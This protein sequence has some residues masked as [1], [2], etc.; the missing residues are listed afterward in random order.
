VLKG[1]SHI[2]RPTQSS[3]DSRGALGRT[4][5]NAAMLGEDDVVDAVRAYL[6]ERGWQYV[7]SAKAVGKQ[8]GEDLVMKRGSTCLS[9]EAKGETSSDPDSTRY[10]EPFDSG[11]IASHIGRAVV[12]ALGVVS[13]GERR[14]AIALPATTAHKSRVQRIAPALE[15]LA[16]TVLWVAADRTVTAAPD[17]LPAE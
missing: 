5:H 12:T 4:A 6:T 1:F 16:V 11:Q 2:D 10:G 7:S 13:T 17:A 8:H 9:V 15:R 3:H 14:A